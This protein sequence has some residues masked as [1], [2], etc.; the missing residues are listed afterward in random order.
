MADSYFRGTSA[1]REV[2]TRAKPPAEWTRKFKPHQ[3]RLILRRTDFDVV[4]RWPK[5][6]E[7][8]G[9]QFRSDGLY[10]A[11]LHLYPDTG[12]GRYVH[13]DKPTQTDIEQVRP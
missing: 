11:G 1:I 10:Y 6:A 4:K 13:A 7:I 12:P 2:L 9:F 8:V 5:A 3:E